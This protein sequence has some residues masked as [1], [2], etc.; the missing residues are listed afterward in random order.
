MYWEVRTPLVVFFHPVVVSLF[1]PPL[2]FSTRRAAHI[3][4]PFFLPSPFTFV[5]G[6]RQGSASAR[7]PAA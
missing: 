3:T 5:T 6:R 1:S 2:A 4:F 7:R